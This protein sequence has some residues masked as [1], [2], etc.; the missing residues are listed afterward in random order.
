MK[1]EKFAGFI[2]GGIIAKSLFD[3]DPMAYMMSFYMEDDRFKEYQAIC[4]DKTLP[5]K[6]RHNFFKKYA[7][8]AI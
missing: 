3:S 8:S 7:R 5:E 2:C 1:K 6:E 4:A